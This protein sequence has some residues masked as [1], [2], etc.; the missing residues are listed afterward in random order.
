M[1]KF[2]YSPRNVKQLK[3]IMKH[4][5]TTTLLFKLEEFVRNKPEKCVKR[6]ELVADVPLDVLSIPEGGITLTIISDHLEKG[7]YI[8]KAEITNDFHI[9]LVYQIINNY[10]DPKKVKELEDALLNIQ[11]FL[12][13]NK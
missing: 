10:E 1:K 5:Q 6:T 12:E 7:A 3:K 9:N 13:E 2:L 8:N 4:E 11:N